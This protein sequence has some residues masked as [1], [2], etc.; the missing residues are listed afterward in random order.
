M[1]EQLE[2]RVLLD[3]SVLHLTTANMPAVAAAVSPFQ[4]SL[5]GESPYYGPSVMGIADGGGLREKPVEIAMPTMLLLTSR[6]LPVVEAEP[7]AFDDVLAPRDPQASS[8]TLGSFV[9]A[10]SGPLLPSSA[11]FVQPSSQ[12][13]L[14]AQGQTGGLEGGSQSGIIGSVTGGAGIS[15]LAQSYTTSASAAETAA[16]GN[17][18]AVARHLD[19]PGLLD[20]GE[21]SMTYEIDVD[22]A[23][24]ILG[25]SLHYAG[26]GG[27]MPVL[28]NVELMSPSGVPLAEIGAQPGGP[29]NPPQSMTLYLKNAP[30]GGHLDIQVLAAAAGSS[31]TA[32]SSA[33]TTPSGVATAPLVGSGNW[34]VSF[35]LDVQK[36]DS[37]SLPQDAGSVLPTTG[38]IGTLIAAQ[39]IQSGSFATSSSSAVPDNVPESTAVAETLPA[40]TRV[41][42]PSTATATTDSDSTSTEGVGFTRIATGP[43][44]SR[45]AGPLGPT[46]ASI[47]ADPTQAVDRHERALSQEIDGLAAAEMPQS[48]SA[49]S[50]RPMTKNP[51]PVSTGR[52]PSTCE[53][54]STRWPRSQAAAVFRSRSRHRDT[55]GVA[56]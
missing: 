42:D 27:E 29:A 46:L 43:L 25:M 34:N 51:A 18:D 40:S 9:Q 47:D 5:Y 31:E 36:Q 15:D 24:Q 4:N 28:G 49:R 11:L 1:I 16:W 20:P 38:A 53:A 23:P 6:S 3:A 55:A 26:N 12:L 2:Y 17:P 21:M 56:G 54:T 41:I 52:L 37:S 50:A 35:V 19:L 8:A 7:L 45:S 10:M 44:A 30:A 32:G 48:G 14:M 13:A 39:P 22:S 33:T